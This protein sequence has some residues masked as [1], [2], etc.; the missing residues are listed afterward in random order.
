MGIPIGIV[1][2]SA[3]G[4]RRV[5]MAQNIPVYNTFLAMGGAGTMARWYASTPRLVSADYIH[6]TPAGAKIVAGEFIQALL[7]DYDNFKRK[8]QP[9][10][11]G[12]GRGRGGLPR[13]VWLARSPC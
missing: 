6:P 12:P 5:A 11:P 9:E 3:P 10:S 4:E 8:P 1:S 7:E 13:A 2:E